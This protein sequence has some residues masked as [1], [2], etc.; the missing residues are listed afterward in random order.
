MNISAC[1]T[2]YQRTSLLY[3]AVTPFLSDE[4]VNEIIISD[5]HSEERITAEIQKRYADNHKVKVH[6]NPKN[7]DC[8]HNKAKSIEL[9]TNEWVLILDSDNIFSRGFVDRIE[10]L[11]V[12]GLNE[13]HIYQPEWAQPHFDFRYLSGKTIHRTNVAELVD[14]PEKGSTTGTLLNAMNYFVNRSEYLR[15][16]DPTMNPVT[17]DSIYQNYRWLNAGNWIYV[18]PDLWYGHRVHENSHYRQNI[19]NTPLGLNDS[20]IE[21]L[22]Q[23]R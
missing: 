16:F 22:K 11:W 12:A 3:E 4:R 19:R 5:D 15:I 6:R 18:V 17:S 13:K 21:K 2:T 20:I 9:A 7:L 1:F 8:Y 14:D 10:N 23:M